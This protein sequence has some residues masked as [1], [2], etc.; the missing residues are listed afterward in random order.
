MAYSLRIRQSIKKWDGLYF[1]M[2]CAADKADRRSQGGRLGGYAMTIGIPAHLLVRLR[3][4]ANLRLASIISCAVILVAPGSAWPDLFVQTNVRG[5]N[6]VSD[7][8]SD[9]S[10]GPCSVGVPGASAS[11]K[12]TF[13]SVDGT[14][15]TSGE[16][17]A[18]VQ[19]RFTD[20]FSFLNASGGST[21]LEVGFSTNG[22]AVSGGTNPGGYAELQ[23]LMSL[24]DESVVFPDKNA[25][26]AE[27][28]IDQEGE[29]P[30]YI[31]GLPL[32]LL[33]LEV[34]EGHIVQLALQIFIDASAAGG[35]AD[36]RDP[37]SIYVLSSN[38]YISDS[39]TV[40]PTSFAS[41]SAVPE[42]GSLLLL[43]AGMAG[44][45]AARGRKMPKRT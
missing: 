24:T 1:G 7:T 42:P 14:A 6:R 29:N 40:Y 25:V 26:S 11:A 22:A 18:E 32:N 39:G 12:A 43:I 35:E 17:E 8:C 5:T 37:T 44:L 4:I 3:V 28:V 33:S 27:Y 30:L 2:F 13:G 19:S 36:V 9:S 15:M 45:G 23:V 34:P 21:H 38:P 20:E 41:V 16:G 10:G 31:E